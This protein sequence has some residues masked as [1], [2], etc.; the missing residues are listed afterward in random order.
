[1]LGKKENFP[2]EMSSDFAMAWR[3]LSW[4]KFE[5][6]LLVMKNLLTSRGAKL[7]V[8]AVPYA[9]QLERS[10][11][12]LDRD[13]TLFPQIQ[14]KDICKMIQVPL[15]DL[16]PIFSTSSCTKLFIDNIHLTDEGHH[17]AAVSVF[18]FLERQGLLPKKTK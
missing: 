1:M 11:L 16:H 17:V 8:V 2:W 15:L 4:Q 12:E 5:K 3:D 14:L 18:N 6:H 13:Y 9:P 10:N 7:V